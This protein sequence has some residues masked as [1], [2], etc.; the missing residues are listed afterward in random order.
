VARG[1]TSAAEPDADRDEVAGIVS[2][3]DALGALDDA[4][5]DDVRDWDDDPA[6]DVPWLGRSRSR[7]VV[8]ATTSKQAATT[9]RTRHRPERSCPD[10]GMIAVRTRVLIGASVLTASSSCRASAAVAGRSAGSLAR[11]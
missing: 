2:D 4:R 11:R 10:V 3:G 8:A 9:A 5:V 7:A 1:T 6:A